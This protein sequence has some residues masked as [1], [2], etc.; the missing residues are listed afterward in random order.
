MILAFFKVVNSRDYDRDEFWDSY[1]E[2]SVIL[3]KLS[4]LNRDEV[5]FY[6]WCV[7]INK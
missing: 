7:S 3:N 4:L 2:P 1:D 5:R 6:K